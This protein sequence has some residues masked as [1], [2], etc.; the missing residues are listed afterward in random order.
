MVPSRGP[1]RN[2]I[3]TM[4]L[5][6]AYQDASG[7]EHRYGIVMQETETVWRMKERL[8]D[9]V[10]VLPHRLR[11]TGRKEL[12]NK[13]TLAKSGLRNGAT[14]TLS[15]DVRGEPPLEDVSELDVAAC[16]AFGEG[17]HHAIAQHPFTFRV[18]LA[19][20]KGRQIHARSLLDEGLIRVE[21]GGVLRG[22]PF[23]LSCPNLSE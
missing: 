12:S 7:T 20:R 19:T 9:V 17:L 11:L 14:I 13:R 18:Y 21:V 8:A 15:V 23:F 3:C 10:G 2:L 1:P 6:V 22:H 16:F 4:K 5:T